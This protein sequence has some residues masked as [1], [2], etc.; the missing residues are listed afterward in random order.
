MG[1]AFTGEAAF[2]FARRHDAAGAGLAAMSLVEDLAELARCVLEYFGV[3][4]DMLVPV[5][6]SHLCGRNRSVVRMIGSSLAL[7]PYPRLHFQIPLQVS[8]PGGHLD[9]AADCPAVATFADVL[10][11]AEHDGERFATLRKVV[12]AR[13]EPRIFVTPSVERIRGLAFEGVPAL[14]GGREQARP[15]DRD[16][17]KKI[18][19]LENELQML[20][21]QIAMIIT[22]PSGLSS[23]ST[24]CP[25]LS[26]P[27]LTSTPRCP[28][29]P[30]PPPPPLPAPAVIKAVATKR[31]VP[32]APAPP[33]A[34]S[35]LDVLK[36]LNKVKLRMV[37]RSPGG[38]PVRKRR[39]KGPGCPSDP[40]ALISEALRKKFAHRHHNSSFD[41][42]NRS[43]ELSPFGSPETHAV[44]HSRRS[45]GRI[46]L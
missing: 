30:P 42:E 21:A 15:T 9:A 2:E 28:P 45:L 27:V 8:R 43:A 5:W 3:P 26:D 37:E 18:S 40:V 20:R 33:T 13:V 32:A 23:P 24:P 29:P 35:M 36:D 1:R 4:A 39:S 16:A 6:D 19:A 12:P 38:T 41:K 31:E 14:P 17:L 7:S 46:H 44:P 11:V 25:S 10:W 22:D 34:P